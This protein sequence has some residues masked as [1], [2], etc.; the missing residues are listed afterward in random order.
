LKKKIVNFFPQKQPANSN[1]I[2]AYHS[3]VKGI[4]VC[5]NKAASLSQR[6]DNYKTVKYGF[7]R[8]SSQE[9]L[10]LHER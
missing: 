4:E 6:G 9:L 2:C 7:Y 10:S 3:L 8:F 1:Q 5:L